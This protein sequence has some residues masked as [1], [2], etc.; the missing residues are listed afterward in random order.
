MKGRQPN[1]Q[2]NTQTNQNHLGNNNRKKFRNES[3]SKSKSK[4]RKCYDCGKIMHYIRDYHNKK[5]EHR[6]KKVDEENVI[7]SAE[8]YTVDSIIWNW[9]I[10]LIIENMSM[11]GFWTQAA[12]FELHTKGLGFKILRR[13]EVEK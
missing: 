2:N 8:P 11:N 7:K 13:Q 5:N 1:R 4:N 6:D 10:M 9:Q 12:T 3:R